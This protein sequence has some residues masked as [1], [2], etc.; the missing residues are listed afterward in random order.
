MKLIRDFE[1]SKLRYMDL[2]G[3]HVFFEGRLERSNGIWTYRT[4][5]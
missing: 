2:L 4:G 5:S 3:D 1:K